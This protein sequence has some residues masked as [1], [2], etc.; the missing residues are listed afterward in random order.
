[1]QHRLRYALRGGEFAFAIPAGDLDAVAEVADS[2]CDFWNGANSVLIA[3]AEDGTIAPTERLFEVREPE[4]IYIHDRIGEVGRAAL[5]E[6]FGEERLTEIYSRTFTHELHPLNLQPT[7]RDPPTDGPKTPLP[8][9]VYD[10]GE[11]ARLA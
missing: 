10:D 9:P 1:M 6:R 3:V 2:C 8:E 5:G 11:L 7:Y 4:Q